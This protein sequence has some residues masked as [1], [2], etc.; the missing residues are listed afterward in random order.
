MMNLSGWALRNKHLVW[1]LVVALALGGIVSVGNMSKL[2]DPEIKVKNALV[3]TTYPGASAH[4]VE[5]EVTDVLEKRIRT[6]KG[7][8]YVKSQSY[9]DLSIISVVL[10]Q[11]VPDDEVEQHYDMLR[12]KV[13]DAVLPTGAGRPVVRDDFGDLYGMF[14]AFT[15]DGMDAARLTD[16]AEMVKRELLGV[17]GVERV[18]LYGSRPQCINISLQE[19]RMANLGVGTAEVLMSLQG[20]NAVVYPGYY[21]NGICRYRVRMSDKFKGTDDIAAMLIQGHDG[22]QMRL[23]DIATV[24][25]DFATPTRNEMT[26]DGESAIGILIAAGSGTDVTKVGKAVDARIE[27]LKQTRMPAGMEFHKVFY[28]PDQVNKALGSFAINLIESIAIVLIIL[29]FFMGVRSGII[30]G[31]SLLLTVLCTFTVLGSVGGTLQRVSL[32]AFIMAMGMLVDN[33]IVI[34]DGIQVG[35]AT[36]KSRLQ[37]LTDIGRQTAMPLLGATLIA[38]LAFWPLYMSPDS[39][40]VYVRDLFVV[41]AVSL[42]L[43]WVLA[44]FHVPLM[45]E[46]MLKAPATASSVE[47]KG[48]P[49]KALRGMLRFG[50]RRPWLF[51]GMVVALLGLSLW[52][53]RFMKNAF[54]PDM[55]YSQLYMEYKLPE[56]SNSTR[57]RA[58]LDSIQQYL[59]S[60]P[61]IAHVTASVGG[62]P[63]RYNLIRSIATP[64]LSYGELIIDF[65]S[66]KELVRNMDEIQEYV[67]SHYPDAY[68]K[69]KRYNLMYK[70]YP[71][72][73]KFT[74]P[75]PAVLHRLSDSARAIMEQSGEVMQ[76]TTDW[77]PQVPVVTIDYNQTSARRSGLSR[78]DVGMSV[79]AATEG[80]PVGFFYDGIHRENVN[81]RIRTADGQPIPDLTQTQVFPTSPSL[82]T[83]LSE[84]NLLKLRAGKLS[85]D[86]LTQQLLGSTPL[87]QVASV[88]VDWE[89]PV[90]MRF[91][92]QRIQTVQCSPMPGH[93]VA[94]TRNHLAEKI[95]QI[96][97]PDGYTRT[98][99]GEYEANGDAMK[100]LFATYPIA[101]L[102]IISI[103]IILFKDYRK[104]LIILCTVPTVLTGVVAGIL[105]SGKAF[106]FVALAGT[107]GLI[108]M[109]IKNSIVL[110][111][112]INLQLSQGVPPAKAL[113]DGSQSRL[114]AV[115]MAALT[116]I[117]GMIPLL[118]DPMFGSMAAAI[119]GGLAYSTVITLVFVPVLYSIFFS[120]K[121]NG[122]EK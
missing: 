74:G 67:Q 7:L 49:Y 98:W 25:K 3:V 120:I 87:S 54:F 39:T 119:M 65:T 75:D 33:A 82:G 102:L 122:N 92:G 101:L 13:G 83:L 73:V 36:G 99:M 42:L 64:S 110:M 59:S 26:Y 89:D 114:R 76:I 51:T 10:E 57:V 84:E 80:V 32:G 115:M 111:D 5:L 104:P 45:G 31:I 94:A 79:L 116:T 90:V 72:E 30:I 86:E 91:N 38:I 95:D 40:G 19:D 88:K 17:D 117:L 20:Q 68:V 69:L 55:D 70:Q 28:Q 8:R 1:F 81:V 61:E 22:S 18:E 108:G 16:Y 44:I 113:V 12:R 58:D 100:Y 53:S 4:E 78:S 93:E 77:A 14:F 112:E 46:R 47:Y 52:G 43:S 105:V 29:M 109:I 24:E 48:V 118:P 9:S 60:R 6:M 106:G 27:Q 15:G 96:P 35:L 21:E 37:A 97:L 56:G 103:L 121:T 62:T 34:V 107:L 85:S 23:G 41:L 11:T 2:E 63:G 71:I 50:L 66:P